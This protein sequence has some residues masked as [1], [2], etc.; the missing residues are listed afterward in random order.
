[1]G[2]PGTPTPTYYN[3][4]FTSVTVC[5]PGTQNCQIIPDILVDTGSVG[6][7][8]LNS[9]LTT[10]PATELGDHPG[11]HRESCAGMRPIWR[12]LLRLGTGDVRRCGYRRRNGH[13][14][15]HP[16]DWRYHFTVPAA[17]CL[18]LGTGP[19]L[20]TVAALGANGIL[21]VGTTVQ[22]CGPN[23]AAEPDLFRLSLLHLPQSGLPDAAVPVDQQVANP[24]AFFTEDNNGVE[25]S[26]PR[27]PPAGAPSLPYV[28][29]D[30]TG[31]VPAGLLIFGV[32]TQ[33]NNALG[34]ATLYAVDDNGNFPNYCL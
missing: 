18:S 15:S 20:D 25:I 34:N 29:S 12:Y 17:S 5:L 32:G 3:G 33:S 13:L 6:L 31:L 7:R 14:R 21:G 22:D 27:I 24:V 10:V 30:G 11:F 2:T 16:G 9:A 19:S 1:M 28:N 8:V 23:C 26:L 4:L